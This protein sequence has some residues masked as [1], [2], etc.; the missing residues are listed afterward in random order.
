MVKKE[1]TRQLLKNLNDLSDVELI[2]ELDAGT[3]GSGEYYQNV[4]K[5][6]LDKRLKIAIQDLTENVKRGNETTAKYNKWLVRLTIAIVAL[7][8]FMLVGLGIQIWLALK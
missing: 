8:F 7:T 6:L 2:E 3:M 1:F 5:G 4:I